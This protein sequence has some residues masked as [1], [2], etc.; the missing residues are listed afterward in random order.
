[1]KHLEDQERKDFAPPYNPAEVDVEFIP[2]LERINAK[3]FAATVQCCIGHCEYSDSSLVPANGSGRWGYLELL[4][5]EQSAT[6]LS[7]QIQGRDWLIEGLSKM[8][9]DE[10][11]ELPGCTDRG[12]MMLAFAWDASCWPTAVEEICALLDQYDDADEDDSSGT[13]EV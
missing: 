11:G 8:W 9:S 1:M 6:W 5:T 4:M 12:N 2:Y 10:P 3:P 7:E 13:G